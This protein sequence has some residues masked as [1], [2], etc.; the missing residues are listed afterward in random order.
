VFGRLSGS[1]RSMR[2]GTVHADSGQPD[3]IATHAHA[4]DAERLASLMFLDPGREAVAMAGSASAA[5]RFQVRMLRRALQTGT[6]IVII[7]EIAS[8]PA[9]FAEVSQGAETPSFRTLATAAVAAMGIAGA[10][11]AAR[12]SLARRK[13]DFA[14]PEGGVHLLELHVA[15]DLRNRG[16]GAFLLARVDEYAISQRAEHVSLTTATDNPARGLY[17]RNGYR[18]VDQKTNALYE[19]ITGSEGRVL[20]VK[21]LQTA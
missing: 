21:P 3:L 13:V 18:L 11:R 1:A 7:A 14:A 17:E 15:P 12:R 4:G 10:L 2:I 20:M 5:E 6:S 19:R 16:V 8:E 9:G